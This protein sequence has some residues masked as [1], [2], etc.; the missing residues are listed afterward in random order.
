MSFRPCNKPPPKSSKECF[1]PA[2][3]HYRH[4]KQE[5]GSQSTARN[6]LIAFGWEAGIRTPI[7]GSRV[8]SLTVRRPPNARSRIYVSLSI[9]ST[10]GQSLKRQS[11]L[12]VN[13]PRNHT[14]EHEL[15]R[16]LSFAGSQLMQ[17]P[18]FSGY[19]FRLDELPNTHRPV[20]SIA[21]QEN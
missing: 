11:D 4:T 21:M 7:G 3:A 8:R 18:S 16:P 12:C 17:T 9:K 5:T 13:D 15:H 19:T 20:G 6:L 10:K 2:L 1:S 14:N